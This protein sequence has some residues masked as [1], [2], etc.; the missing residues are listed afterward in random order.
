VT[1]VAPTPVIFILAAIIHIATLFLQGMFLPILWPFSHVDQPLLKLFLQVAARTARE[2]INDTSPGTR[3]G[4]VYTVHAFSRDIGFKPD[5]HLF[6]TKGGLNHNNRV[7]IDGFFYQPPGIEMAL[8]ALPRPCAG[9][10]RRCGVGP[11]H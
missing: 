8:L 9:Y 3:I 2:I 6:M 10:R 1:R 11:V 4:M 5:V 7:E